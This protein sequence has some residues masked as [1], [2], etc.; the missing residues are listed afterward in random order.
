MQQN[1]STPKEKVWLINEAKNLLKYK[2]KLGRMPIERHLRAFLCIAQT[3]QIVLF[4]KEA[5]IKV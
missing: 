5:C 4:P 1:C 3:K 2:K